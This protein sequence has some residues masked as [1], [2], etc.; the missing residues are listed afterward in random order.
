M[1]PRYSDP[2]TVWRYLP[3]VIHPH[4]G[5]C[6]GVQ[7]NPQEVLRIGT[8]WVERGN[9]QLVFGWIGAPY[10]TKVRSSAGTPILSETI[11]GKQEL[12]NA[13]SDRHSIKG[14]VGR[15]ARL[16]LDNQPSPVR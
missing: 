5:I 9:R 2:L 11:H 10:D 15:A 12:G 6:A 1:P 14:H 3:G 16:A 7:W 8:H 13:A 4:P